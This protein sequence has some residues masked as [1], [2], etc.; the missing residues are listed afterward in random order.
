MKKYKRGDIS[1]EKNNRYTILQKALIHKDYWE[2]INI[3]EIIKKY[4]TSASTVYKIIKDY[5]NKTQ[6]N[7]LN[8]E[9]NNNKNY[10]NFQKQISIKDYVKP[11]QISLTINSINN[12][13]NKNFEEKWRKREIKKFLKD[14]LNYSYKKG[15]LLL[16]KEQLI[17]Q[18]FYIQSFPLEF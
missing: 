9:E 2:N 6:L 16:L 12:G 1:S 17:K 14:S 5:K 8:F 4:N 11:P 18:N 3:K 7:N 10:L 15:L 13:L